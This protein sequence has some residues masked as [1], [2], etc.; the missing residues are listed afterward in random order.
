MEQR[1]EK[2]PVPDAPLPGGPVVGAT[3]P[4][5][6]RV[7]RV[8]G[9]RVPF[10]YGWVIVGIV[11]MGELLAS[12]LGSFI[13]PLFFKPMT[14]EMG[15]SLTLLTGVIT[16][17]T[18]ANAATAPILGNLMDRLGAKPIMIFGSVFAGVGLLML[19]QVREI[20]QLWVLY[21]AV[22]V[23]GLNEMGGFTGPVLVTKWFVRRRGKALSFATV[24]TTLGGAV[25]API[26]GVLIAGVGWRNTLGIM[27]IVLMVIMVPLSVFLVKRQPEDIGLLPDGDLSPAGPPTKVGEAPRRTATS[28]V[29]YTVKEAT[30]TRAIWALIVGLNLVQIAGNTSTLFFVPFLMLQE[31]MSAQIASLILTLR[32]LSSTLSRLVWG[33][34]ADR[35]PVHYLLAFAFFS[36]AV[37]PL[38]LVLLPYP[39]NVAVMLLTNITAG[40]FVV[41]QNMAFANYYG[42]RHSG[43][44]QGFTRPF[45][46]V[47]SLAGP[48]IISRVYDMTGTFNV[49]FVISALVGLL[50]VPIALLATPPKGRPRPVGVAADKEAVRTP[51]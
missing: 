11:F 50:S 46:T 7:P 30:R 41:L 13:V 36:R 33:F 3:P 34:A 12:G 5:K 51:R 37:G 15:W 9:F 26:V 18:V 38:A 39:W 14:D 10:Y 1:P 16:A 43:A 19:T 28:E 45:L 40:G 6:S 27:G 4:A 22:G 42:R 49:I 2:S 35:F 25:M 23:L 44:I 32:L 47:T 20:W 21:A 24:G 31:G 48:L 29:S 8:F 17:Q